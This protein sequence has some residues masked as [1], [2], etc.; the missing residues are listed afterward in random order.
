MDTDTTNLVGGDDTASATVADD[1]GVEADGT[2]NDE[3]L[4]DDD[5]NPI[6][7]AEEEEEVDLGDLKLRVPKTAAE[8]LK[9]LQE[10]NLRQA[11]YTR[12][13]QEVAD[14]RKAVEAERET[15]HQASEAEIGALATVR[16]IDE[17][18]AQYA[19]ADWARWEQDDFMAAQTGWREFSQLKDARQAA[20]AQYGT[21]RT[22]R[23][24]VQQQETAKLV[25]KAR[26]ELAADPEIKWSPQKA[27]E[28]L[29]GAKAHYKLDQSEV[30][31]GFRDAR[32]VR[33]LH[34]ALQWRAHQ[35]KS[36]KAQNH[37]SAQQVKPAAKVGGG[38]APPQG[39]D[40]R[41][42]ADEWVKRRNQQVRK[43]A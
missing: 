37:V 13:T 22:Q 6:A 34:D 26:A 35:A 8:K 21:L 11:D 33:I 42:S 4:F 43:R 16:A 29:S 5:G 10:G 39:L 14:L 24:S 3:T 12:K 9:E 28:M 41:L 32:L 30:D 23:E 31:D 18:L 20:A 36:N 25:E 1:M 27:A 15:I 17:R 2:T 7:P 38:S 19:N 40:D